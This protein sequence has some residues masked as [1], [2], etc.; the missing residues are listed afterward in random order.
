[1]KKAY[2]LFGS[3]AAFVAVVLIVIVLAVFTV[4][5][6][7]VI[8]GDGEVIKE[9]R[10]VTLFDQV[11]V[12]DGIKV[13]YAPSDEPYLEVEGEENIVPEVQATLER[14]IL[15]IT[16]D[17]ELISDNLRVEAGSP[18]LEKVTTRTSGA[19]YAYDTVYTSSMEVI[20]KSE[21]RMELLGIFDEL[22]VETYSGA[23]IEFLGET[24]N[25]NVEATSE[26]VA[27][28]QRFES[29]LVTVNAEQNAEA[30]VHARKKLTAT[31]S[32]NGKIYYRGNPEIEYVNF[33]SGAGM[34][35]RP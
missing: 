12:E 3:L 5:E 35:K 31:G 16:S 1:M 2:L 33:S 30:R 4:E 8:E 6:Q 13:Y 19:F 23:E 15:E 17:K 25:K 29:D 18:E 34:D 32:S 26:S 24:G 27:R 7:A 22:S 20:A 11:V 21:S 28:L 14:G 10:E 9:S